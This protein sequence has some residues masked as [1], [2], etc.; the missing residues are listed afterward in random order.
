MKFYLISTL[1]LILIGL[2]L[3]EEKNYVGTWGTALYGQ[4]DGMDLDLEGNSFREIVRTSIPGEVLRF[5]FSNIFSQSELEILSVHVARSAGQGTGAIVLDT[6]TPIT[7]NGHDS[8]TLDAHAEI[9]SDDIPFDLKPLDELAITIHYGKVPLEKTSHE[10]SRTF[11]FFE[12]GDAVSKE[13]FV[14]TYKIQRY[15]SLSGIDVLDNE[16]KYEAIVCY[17]DSITDGRG[18]TTDHQDR[19]PDVLSER[20]Q[21]S[22]YTQHFAILN[23]S[24]GATTLGGNSSDKYPTALGRFERDI[25]EENNV[26]Y[27][28]VL[29]G[30]NDITSRRSADDMIN[31]FKQLISE[32]HKLGITVY[33]SPILPCE[34]SNGWDEEMAAVKSKVNDWIVNTLASEGGFDA[35]VDLATPLGESSAP[36]TLNP[37]LSDGDGLHPN[38]L[39]YKAMGYAV[40]LGLF[41]N[42][43]EAVE[44]NNESETEYV[45]TEIEDEIDSAEESNS[46]LE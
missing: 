17:G 24:I 7:F 18:S 29:Y 42:D 19:W 38:G 40:D 16:R 46:D 32:A 37:A 10:T 23:K 39:G 8:V 5:R 26:K 25:I 27:M 2:V 3:A 34:T 35:V 9:V 21:S 31:D 12:F 20:L 33:G 36:L 11:S 22:P 30:V 45:D 14:D 28:I 4:R 13:Q 41:I 6:D 44:T 43:V 1:C 15:L